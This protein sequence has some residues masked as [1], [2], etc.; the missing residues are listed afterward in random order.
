MSNRT[1]LPPSLH[2]KLTILTR[3]L[4]WLHTVR[5]AS[6]VLLVLVLTGATVLLADAWLDFPTAV[7]V[8]LLACWQTT[9][10]C[11]PQRMWQKHSTQVSEWT[12]SQQL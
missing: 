9:A 8:L 1:A 7:R 4:R 12:H 5:G 11:W 3:R 6:R 10:H 2:T